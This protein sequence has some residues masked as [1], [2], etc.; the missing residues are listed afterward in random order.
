[1]KFTDEEKKVRANEAAKEWRDKNT[2]VFL[3]KNAFARFEDELKKYEETL[4]YGLKNAQFLS[5]LLDHWAK[6]HGH[7]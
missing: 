2:P 3:T 7:K 6:T 5:V 4:V 1:M